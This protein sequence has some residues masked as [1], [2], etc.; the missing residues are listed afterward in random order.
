MLPFAV[1]GLRKRLWHY[2]TDLLTA[3]VE[4]STSEKKLNTASTILLGFHKFVL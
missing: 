1:K 2:Q 4:D 3:L